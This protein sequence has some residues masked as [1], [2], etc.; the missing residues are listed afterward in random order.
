MLSGW[1]FRIFG[2]VSCSL[3]VFCEV[4]ADKVCV[5][6]AIMGAQEGG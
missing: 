5:I 4:V 3:F 1:R 6:E 2:R